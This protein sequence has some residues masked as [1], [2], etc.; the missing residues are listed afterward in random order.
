MSD[1]LIIPIPSGQIVWLV[2]CLHVG[3]SD[4]AVVREFYGRM[5]KQ[6]AFT[7]RVRKAIYR[8][9]LEQH[10]GNQGFYAAIQSGRI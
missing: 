2:N 10:H 6:P 7:K 5:R 8:Y 3:T 1:A 4:A 9:A